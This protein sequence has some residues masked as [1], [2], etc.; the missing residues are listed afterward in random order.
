M[1]VSFNSKITGLDYT[2]NT[3]ATTSSNTQGQ[4]VQEGKNPTN[5]N[6]TI[7]T[8]D[9]LKVE[10]NVKTSAMATN[11]FVDKPFDVEGKN[12]EPQGNS[13]GA[14]NTSGLA[15]AFAALASAFCGVYLGD[16]FSK[17]VS[18]GL[19][20]KLEEEKGNYNNIPANAKK[21]EPEES[22]SERFVKNSKVQQ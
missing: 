8:Q 21:R 13:V 10:N 19:T 14:C 6:S 3:Q 1:S 17:A 9:G 7:N 20:R 4:R 15:H 16:E 5:T 22:E 2:S 18:T 11:S 12:T